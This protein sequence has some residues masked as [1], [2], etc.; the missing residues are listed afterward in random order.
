[1]KNH[2]YH[3]KLEKRKFLLPKVEYLDHQ[4]SSDG[5]QQIPS[6]VA[7]IAKALTPENLTQLW[8]FSALPPVVA[9]SYGTLLLSCNC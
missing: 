9:I 6:K 3:L 2:G 7:T 8:S 1:M 4:I 5:I